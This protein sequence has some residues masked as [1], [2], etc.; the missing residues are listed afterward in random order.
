MKKK[1]IIK[2]GQLPLIINYIEGDK[3]NLD[4]GY[5][6]V[7]MSIALLAGLNIGSNTLNA[8]KGLKNSEVKSQ[9]VKT[10][11]DTN[12]L[13]TV[14]NSLESIGY[15]DAE[16][17]IMSNAKKIKK[18][19]SNPLNKPYV[20]AT[21][22][23]DRVG[24]LLDKG[25]SI[26]DVDT[27]EIIKTLEN[28]DSLDVSDVLSYTSLDLP[29]S[30][31]FETGGYVLKSDVESHIINLIKELKSKG[32]FITGVNIESSTDKEPI[33]KFV[34]D[35]DSTGNIKLSN[36]RINSIKDVFVTNGV[37]D[38]KITECAI[39]NNPKSMEF[40]TSMS[41]NDRNEARLASESS[42]YVKVV[43]EVTNPV[44]GFENKTE[45]EV[46]VKE[47]VLRVKMVKSK[48]KKITPPTITVFKFKGLTPKTNKDHHSCPNKK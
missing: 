47:L 17:K 44:P 43:I 38:N 12:S 5:K 39:P 7:V 6:E 15:S 34:T 19:L 3:I 29:S 37:N 30:N 13:S 36:L 16:E 20:R 42:R 24:D 1:L 25:Y 23:I 28:S 41:D 35:D 21:N 31:M 8:Q 22:D 33:R 2:E 45:K 26:Y 40:N 32:S 18:E 48:D 11:N 10:L 9:I 4:E 46:K 14:I 27:V